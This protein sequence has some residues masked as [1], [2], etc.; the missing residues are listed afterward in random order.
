MRRWESGEKRRRG[1][2]V[3]PYKKHMEYPFYWRGVYKK[4]LE[5]LTV[6]RISP[7]CPIAGG[8]GIGNTEKDRMRDKQT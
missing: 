1:G 8:V 4:M 3:H 2:G 6:I 7:R 5:A